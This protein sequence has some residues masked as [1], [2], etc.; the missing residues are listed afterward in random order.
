MTLRI[1][2]A[3]TFLLLPISGSSQTDQTTPISIEKEP[4]HNPHVSKRTRTGLPSP[5]AAERGDKD[6]SAHL[7]LRLFLITASNDLKR[8]SRSYSSYHPVR[9]R[10][11]ANFKGRI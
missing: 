6:S 11:T 9:K 3:I 8:S 2:F 5:V 10:R 4:H 1:W 7:V